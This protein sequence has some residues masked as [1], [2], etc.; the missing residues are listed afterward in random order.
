[1]V[2]VRLRAARS[3]WASW[4]SRRGLPQSVASY[5]ATNINVAIIAIAS[6]LGTTVI[7]VQTAMTLFSLMM[8]SLMIPG[9]KLTDVWGRKR[10]SVAGLCIRRSPGRR[11][12]RRTGAGLNQREAQLEPVLQRR[13]SGQLSDGVV[14]ARAGV[15]RG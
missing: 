4:C 13:S 6:D 3:Q 1:M 15:V 5:A 11:W 14:Q 12:R 2:A 7:G 9:S 8:A 10:L